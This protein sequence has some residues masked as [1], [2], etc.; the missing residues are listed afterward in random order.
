MAHV[1]NDRI[2]WWSCES[3]N[4]EWPR[5]QWSDPHETEAGGLCRLTDQGRERSST[6]RGFVGLTHA[7]TM[8]TDEW[9]QC[10]LRT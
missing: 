8:L 6:N 3:C 7:E 1:K 4:Y 9:K 5:G 2:A 10:L